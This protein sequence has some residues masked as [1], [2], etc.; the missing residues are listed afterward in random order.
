M[1]TLTPNSANRPAN[2]STSRSSSVGEP[3]MERRLCPKGP[4]HNLAAGLKPKWHM[5]FQQEAC[6]VLVVSLRPAGAS[7]HILQLQAGKR[8][9]EHPV[10]TKTSYGREGST[11]KGDANRAH[12]TPITA[13]AQ[14]CT[15][16]PRTRET[17][18]LR[19]A[20][21]SSD[22]YLQHQTQ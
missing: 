11:H 6:G 17:A 13:T 21:E 12:C 19:R 5:P 9:Q 18:H 3:A 10:Q 1:T 16:W 8:S 7:Q 4:R 2:S 20:H 15:L 14:I 22:Y